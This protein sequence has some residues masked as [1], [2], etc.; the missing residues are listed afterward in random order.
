MCVFYMC[1]MCL[2]MGNVAKPIVIQLKGSRDCTMIV[3][4]FE[5]SQFG[6]EQHSYMINSNVQFTP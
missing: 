6:S 5:T 3:W 1:Y 2:D 4:R